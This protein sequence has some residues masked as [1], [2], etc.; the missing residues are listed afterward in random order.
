MEVKVIGIHR[1]LIDNSIKFDF[2]AWPLLS[3]L[4]RQALLR[5]TGFRPSEQAMLQERKFESQR[6]YDTFKEAHDNILEAIRAYL[7]S[8][9]KNPEKMVR[10]TRQIEKYNQQ[11]TS[12]GLVDQVPLITRNSIMTQLRG[13]SAPKKKEAA[14]LRSQTL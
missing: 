1:P 4:V 8:P 6:V 2:A 9:V 7:I 12:Q 3:S 11:V 5:A 14:R 13:V 10:I